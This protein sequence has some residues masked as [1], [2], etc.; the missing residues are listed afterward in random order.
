[1][2][3]PQALDGGEDRARILRPAQAA[4]PRPGHAVEHGG[5]AVGDGL[6]VAFEQRDVERESHAGARHQLP[7]EGIAVHVDDAG[8]HQQTR[9]VDHPLGRRVGT[10][11]RDDSCRGIEVEAGVLEAISDQHTATFNAELHDGFRL[12]PLERRRW[13]EH[14]LLRKPVPT[15][16]DHAL[17]MNEGR[18]VF[19]EKAVDR[20]LAEV[21]QRGA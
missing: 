10:D 9:R 1:V 20:Q 19:L 15:F 7:L 12:R 8:Q 13:L 21:G 3:A 17:G 16:R 4:L 18:L 5:D 2:S 14:D 6:T 11:R